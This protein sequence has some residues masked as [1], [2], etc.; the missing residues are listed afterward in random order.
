MKPT[1]VKV[2]VDLMGEHPQRVNVRIK[3][4]S[5]EIVSKWVQIKY[6]YLPKYCKTCKLEGHNK[7]DCFVLHPELF[8]ESKKDNE[9]WYSNKK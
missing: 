5:R 8:E 9:K 2:E 3:K 6:D 7:D 1:K 4:K